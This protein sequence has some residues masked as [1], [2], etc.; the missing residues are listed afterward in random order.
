MKGCMSYKHLRWPPWKLI[1]DIIAWSKSYGLTA[2]ATSVDICGH[3]I[4][5]SSLWK[6]SSINNKSYLHQKLVFFHQPICKICASQNGWT[7]SPIFGVKHTYF[8]LPPPRDCMP[9]VL[10]QRP[11]KLNHIGSLK[12]ASYL[13]TI[14]GCPKM[15]V[16]Q[17]GW[18]IMENPIKMDDLGGTTI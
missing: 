17:N 13:K 12:L 7:S 2:F 15:V 10:W 8:E 11:S 14:W 6:K 3:H 16:P 4:K 9:R 1:K 18:F 5:T